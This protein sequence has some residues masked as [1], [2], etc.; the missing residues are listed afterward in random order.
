MEARC[1]VD[2]IQ[3]TDAVRRNRAK[4]GV[5]RIAPEHVNRS[6]TAAADDSVDDQRGRW[7]VDQ[8]I[9]Q[10][11]PVVDRFRWNPR[12]RERLRHCA[13]NPVVARI[14]LTDADDAGQC[15][16]SGHGSYLRSIDRRKKCVAHEMQGS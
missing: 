15:D 8:D 7:P 1:E 2:G 6:G 9:E 11:S 3:N 5:E 16:G 12:G 14:P 13:P 10:P 4:R